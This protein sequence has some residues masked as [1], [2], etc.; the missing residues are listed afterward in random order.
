LEQHHQVNRIN[1]V[2][3]FISLFIPITGIR[4]FTIS[5]VL[6][7][8]VFFG[9]YKYRKND[10][11]KQLSLIIGLSFLGFVLAGTGF[12]RYWLVLLPIIYLSFYY[13]YSSYIKKTDY[14]IYAFNLISLILVL[15]EM[16]ITLLL[17]NK[18]A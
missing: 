16:R 10:I 3:A 17:I 8:A 15:N 4:N 9:L 1:G 2:P 11:I 18:I 14:F 13:L 6:L 7:F 5:L 12:S